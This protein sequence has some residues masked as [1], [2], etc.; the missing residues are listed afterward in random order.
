MRGSEIK[1]IIFVLNTRLIPQTR[2]AFKSLSYPKLYISFYSEVEIA[3]MWHELIKMVKDK[4]Y[5]HISTVTDNFIVL[6]E[7]VREVH[8]SVK[9]NPNEIY[10][11]WSHTPLSQYSN[12]LKHRLT[13]EYPDIWS[14][15]DFYNVNELLIMSEKNKNPRVYLNDMCFHTMSVRLWEM[16]PFDCFRASNGSDPNGYMCDYHICYRL[17]NANIPMNCVTKSRLYYHRQNNVS[18]EW[19]VWMWGLKNNPKSIYLEE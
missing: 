9:Q 7:A 10:C 1:P 5:T 2:D 19:K 6:N 12:I 4:G 14:M 3:D 11:S 18:P 15:V 16:F 13:G 8:N 17:Q